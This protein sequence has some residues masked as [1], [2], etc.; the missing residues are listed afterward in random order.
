MRGLEEE[1]WGSMNLKQMMHSGSLR[2]SEAR[3][4][5]RAMSSSLNSAPTVGVERAEKTVVHFRSTCGP[6]SLNA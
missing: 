5:R 1:K 3:A 6:D 2:R 4:D